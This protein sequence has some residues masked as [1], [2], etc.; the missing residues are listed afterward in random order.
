MTVV[1]VDRLLYASGRSPDRLDRAVRIR[2]LSPGWRNSFERLRSEVAG[3]QASHPAGAKPA[4]P[5]FRT[6]RVVGKHDETAEVCSVEFGAD[7][8]RPLPER[9]PGQH[10]VVKLPQAGGRAHV[11]R[12]YSLSGPPAAPTFRIGVKREYRGSAS[13]HIHDAV[14]V[15]DTL[16]VSAPRGE[17]VMASGRRPVVLVS[18][19]IGL[20][21]LLSMLHAEVRR[22]DAG[23]APRGMW[24]VHGAANGSRHAFA[25]EVRALVAGR[26]S[27]RRVVVFSRPESADRM[28]AAFDDAGHLDA[29]LLARLGF[30]SDA[31]FY[32]C[33]PVGFLGD[34]ENAL[35]SQGFAQSSIHRESFA[36]A[37]AA[38]GGA[39][40]RA[41]APE[42][43][44]GDGPAVTFTRSGLSVFWS[45]RY[46]SL[47]E[48]AEACAVGVDWSCRAGVCH[49]C[50][51]V[52]VGGEV[53]Y[54]SELLDEPPDGSVLLCC[55]K[56]ATDVQ[57]EI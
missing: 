57:I 27:L 23:G 14:R 35:L 9:S 29:S 18:A 25:E 17:F 28:G 55:A 36:P 13:N 47:L 4:W 7:D 38:T 37:K 21:P 11:V 42:G 26:Q 10:V 51:S 40:V 50:E 3:G 41:R 49:R 16:Q 56:P 39:E 2:A 43:A 52:L 45:D 22:L 54:A 32:L 33:G 30:P 8:G 5:G 1:E 20:T 6:L 53:S 24:W 31:E 34:I 48:L 12:S 44:P 15:G 19:G 46:A